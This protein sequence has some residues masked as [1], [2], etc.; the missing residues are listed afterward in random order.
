MTRHETDTEFF[1]FSDDFLKENKP[2]LGQ[3]M[4]KSHNSVQR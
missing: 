2:N 4:P 3:F 1:S